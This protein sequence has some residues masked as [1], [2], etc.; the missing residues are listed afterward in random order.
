MDP[1]LF[2]PQDLKDRGARIRRERAA[3]EI[4]VA[5]PVVQECRNHALTS[6]E[7]HGIWGGTSERERRHLGGVRPE[8][9]PTKR[10]LQVVRRYRRAQS[11]GSAE[12][13]VSSTISTSSG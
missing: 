9:R 5:C 6:G 10:P 4:C 2:F 8:T 12:V 3:K 7:D 1:E 11:T 13:P